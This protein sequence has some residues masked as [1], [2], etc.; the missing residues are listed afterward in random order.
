MSVAG[1]GARTKPARGSSLRL[2]VPM[3]AIAPTCVPRQTTIATRSHHDGLS[4]GEE[5]RL[6]KP[7]KSLVF[8]ASVAAMAVAGAL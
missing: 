8:A 3:F 1:N 5:S 4:I 2:Q 6:N 7:N